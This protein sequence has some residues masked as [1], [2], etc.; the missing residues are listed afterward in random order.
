LVFSMSGLASWGSG[1]SLVSLTGSV[2]SNAAAGTVPDAIGVHSFFSFESGANDTI[3]SAYGFKS[4]IN[5]A[6]SGNTLVNIFYSFY[7]SN[8]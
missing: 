7:S 3:T 4:E 1:S 5:Q 2:Y 6:G 8:D